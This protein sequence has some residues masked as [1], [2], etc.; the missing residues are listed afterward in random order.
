[1]VVPFFKPQQIK[2][3]TPV[4]GGSINR[5]SRIE[6]VEGES[7]FVKQNSHASD[8]FFNAEKINLQ[9]IAELNCIRTPKV[10]NQSQ[11]ALLLEWIEPGRL[12]DHF[13][14]QLGQQLAQMHQ[15][16]Q[17]Y[18]GFVIN[19][20]CGSTPQPNPQYSDG[21]DF[22]IEQRLLYQGQRAQSRGLLSAKDF[23]SLEQ[24]CVK[25]PSLVPNQPAALLH[26]DLW[27]GNIMADQ[28][29][30]P[31]LVDPACYYGWPEADLAMTTMFGR[32][33]D[34]FYRAY[35]QVRTLEPD[36][37]QRIDLYNLYHWLNH[38]NLFGRGYLA[39]V[40]SIIHRYS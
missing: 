25:L 10:I 15:V 28:N 24:L 34:I 35:R 19:N 27:S 3:V 5:C 21:M 13:W 18:F 4:S 38:L 32:F 29:S 8:D 9:Q 33:S 6:T 26:G 37:E 20:Y 16:T 12:S 40:K 1:M 23:E 30:E 2:S 11:Y 39:E 31:V 36:F 14:Q 7:F 17:G 22:F